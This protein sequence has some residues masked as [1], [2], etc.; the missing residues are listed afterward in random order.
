MSLQLQPLN[1]YFRVNVTG[2]DL[3]NE[4]D[5]ATFKEKLESFN[6]YGLIIIRGQK[7]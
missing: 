1:P 3:T 4:M 7:L 5:D 6:Q 2:I